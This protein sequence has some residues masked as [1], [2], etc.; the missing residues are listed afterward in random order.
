MESLL[1]KRVGEIADH[2]QRISDLTYHKLQLVG[3]SRMRER[4]Q[5]VPLELRVAELHAAA[6]TL[7]AA[8]LLRRV[9]A[10]TDAPIMLMK[11]PE[12]AARWPSP[13]LRPW[14]DLDV[15]VADAERIQAALVGAGFVE[16][17]DAEEYH[18]I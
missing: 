8:P 12:A 11:G 18:E 15:L 5:E 9:R 4:G 6:I 1:W 10:T 3:A 16:L 2:A 7:T 14:K 17:G 13:K